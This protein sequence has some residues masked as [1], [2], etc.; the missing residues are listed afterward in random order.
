MVSQANLLILHCLL[1]TTRARD[2]PRVHDMLE[3]EGGVHPARGFRPALPACRARARS[4]PPSGCLL[5]VSVPHLCRT[6]Q[7]G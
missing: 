2:S 3:P 5:Q 4:S 6:C 7:G 1:D